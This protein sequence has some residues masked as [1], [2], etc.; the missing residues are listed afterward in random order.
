VPTTTAPAAAVL[1]YRADWSTGLGGWVGSDDWA[2]AGGQL[3]NNGEGHGTEASVTAPV[4]IPAGTDF[5]VEAEIQLVRNSDGG[6]IS[7]MGSFGVVARIG[8]DEEGYGV[9]RCVAAGIFTC[10]PGTDDAVAVLWTARDAEVL[11]QTAFQP[12]GDPHRYRL[13][14]R[15]NQLTALIDGSP[16]LQ[17]TDNS[18]LA[19]A[20]V[21]LWSDRAQ[22]SVRGFTVQA[23]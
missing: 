22:V 11:D 20:R 16:V 19:G 13:E 8:A 5:A 4:M 1:P 3:V 12:G 14:V 23:L 9:G 18:Y 2:V 7:G 17:A 6:K 21:G 10:G 15:G